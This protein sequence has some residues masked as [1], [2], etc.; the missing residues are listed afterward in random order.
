MCVCCSHDF[1]LLVGKHAHPRL[2]SRDPPV[3]EPEQMKRLNYTQP[4]GIQMSVRGRNNR[5]HSVYHSPLQA[6]ARLGAES[7]QILEMKKR[8][9]G[10][11]YFV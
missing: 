8:L 1:P 6:C 4:A 3:E 7:L 2:G 9:H 5:N 10:A 11:F